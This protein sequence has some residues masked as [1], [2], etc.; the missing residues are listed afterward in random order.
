M[1]NK[2]ETLKDI[3]GLMYDTEKDEFVKE[4]RQ[5]AINWIKELRTNAYKYDDL[6]HYLDDFGCHYEPTV[7]FIKHF[8]NITEEDLEDA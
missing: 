2:L 6:F 5:E 8:F 7:D 1:E 3:R 4:I